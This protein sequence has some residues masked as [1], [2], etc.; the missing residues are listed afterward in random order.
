VN[1]GAVDFDCPSL[2]DYRLYQDPTEP[3]LAPNAGGTPFDLTT[4]LF[5]DY[6]QK[7]RIVY[8]PPGL[9]ASYDANGVFEFPVGT[10]IAKT[11]TFSHDLRTPQLR[12]TDVVETRLLIRRA[13]GWKG[14]AYIWDPA[15]TEALLAIGGGSKDVAWTADDGTPRTTR[16]QIPN[17]AQ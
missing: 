16:Y 12:G 8:I 3:R 1:W 11:F 4:P 6:A 7:D 9:Q 17:T 2:A 15:Q 14:R 5:S 10:I 13:G